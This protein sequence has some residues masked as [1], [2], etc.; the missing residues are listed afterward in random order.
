MSYLS[1]T[2][3][4]REEM[5]AAIGVSS[6]EELF[7]DIPAGVRLGR[8]LLEVSRQLLLGQLRLE[9]ELATET[10]RDGNVPEEVV[11]GL[12]SDRLEHR[13]PIGVRERE[14]RMRHC[15]ATTCLYAS[16]SS[17]ASTSDG[18]LRRMRTSQPSP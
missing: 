13:L 3:R 8:E 12:D 15:S 17:K 1:L 10:N 6:V 4:D 14:I 7:A 9:F 18:S 16:A 2:E 5:L 11:D